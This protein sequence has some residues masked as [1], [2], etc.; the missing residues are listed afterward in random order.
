MNTRSTMSDH[1][2]RISRGSP[3]MSA[4]IAVAVILGIGAAIWLGEIRQRGGLQV[5]Q[6]T[7]SQPL[8]TAT[9][10]DVAIAMGIG[11]LQLDAR[12]RFSHLI[13][14]TVAH[15][16][17]EQVAHDFRMSSQIAYYSLRAHDKDTSFVPFRLP[18][19]QE[20]RW[21]LH[22]NPD[23][24]MALKVD[25][26]AGAAQLNLA[27]LRAT[28]VEVNTGIGTTILTLPKAGQPRVAIDGGI[29][30]TTILIPA[31]MAARIDVAAGLG[32]T[33]VHGDYERHGNVYVSPD[34]ETATNRV[35]M[36][37]TG[38]IGNITIRHAG[39]E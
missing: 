15:R 4:L 29:G 27:D 34:Y 5:T 35:E 17:S 32:A 18:S 36:E 33:S 12:E 6:E 21:D 9:R 20:V 13:H 39:N 16:A 23:I 1:P 24:P 28:N 30:T 31:G 7:I 38:G 3:R 14:G 8:A 22:L 2:A 25:T 26:G 10:A 11:T 19:K 37:V